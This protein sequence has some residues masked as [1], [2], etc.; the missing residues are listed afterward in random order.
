MTVRGASG[1]QPLTLPGATA[2]WYE[3]TIYARVNGYVA[4]WYVDIGDR[5][6]QGQVLALIE[7]PELDADL[8]AARAELSA[9][10]AQEKVRVA[11]AEFARTTNERWRDSPKGVV[12]DQEREAKRSDYDSAAAKLN[13][14]HAQIALDQA[15]VDRFTAL[16][17]FKQVVA[18]I[19]G[20]ITERR[21][22]I[23]NLVTAGSTSGNTPLYKVSQ[24]SP[25]RVFIDVPQSAASDLMKAGGP[26]QI[27]ANN[28][29]DRP[30]D[31]KIA[32]TAKA[33]DPQSRTLRVEVDLP[34]TDQA[35]VPGMYVN[36]SFQLQ[37]DNMVQVPPAALV[38]RSSGPQV[39]V[40][41]AGGR[42]GFRK[43]T[44]ARDNGNSVSLSSGV[45]PGDRVV[46]NISSQIGDGD[47][48]AVSDGSEG[49]P[50]AASKQAE[51]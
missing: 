34:N 2:A 42:V 13:A 23:G 27:R 16:T 19:D 36:V 29:P 38:F 40:V 41:D 14:A 44:I 1:N 25:M 20:T 31:A 9:A 32:R 21:I 28:L 12:S 49:T 39:A 30:F 22:D 17:R 15:K 7:T 50:A 43:V 5:V 4:K 6:H 35:L 3:T 37:G 18:P 33:I 51:R 10:Q 24:E 45:E 8:T 47:L 26:V 46:L 48:V 11:E